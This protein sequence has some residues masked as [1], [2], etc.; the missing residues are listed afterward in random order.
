MDDQVADRLQGS[1]TYEQAYRTSEL[2]A[3]R[4]AFP[5]HATPAG[6]QLFALLELR[7]G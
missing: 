4:T 2:S 7:R 5:S 1:R 3:A 6:Y